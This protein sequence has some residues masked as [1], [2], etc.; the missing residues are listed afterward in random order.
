[1]K[2]RRRRKFVA[3]NYEVVATNEAPPKFV[4]TPLRVVATNPNHRKSV[5]TKY[6]SVATLFGDLETRREESDLAPHVKMVLAALKNEKAS[7]DADL[8]NYATGHGTYKAVTDRI[9]AKAEEF[10]ETFEK[11]KDRL[12]TDFIELVER[13]ELERLT[14]ILHQI[15]HHYQVA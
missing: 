3:T 7:L 8:T 2:P 6:K 12:T 13:W 14:P 4:A 9:E 5:A 1:M 11:Y 10:R 15:T